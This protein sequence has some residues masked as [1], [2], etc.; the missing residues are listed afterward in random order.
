MKVV[1]TAD[2]PELYFDDEP[3]TLAVKTKLTESKYFLGLRCSK[4]AA[5]TTKPFEIKYIGPIK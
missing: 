4:T 2:G 5:S 3:V 1:L